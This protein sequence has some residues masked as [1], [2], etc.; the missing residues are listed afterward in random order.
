M[1]FALARALLLPGNRGTRANIRNN[2]AILAET[3]RVIPGGFSNIS[4][5]SDIAFVAIDPH[6]VR[7]PIWEELG[8]G[9]CCDD[10]CAPIKGGN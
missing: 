8:Y 7:A 10:E 2:A 5:I 6:T 1:L 9:D 3:L 4:F